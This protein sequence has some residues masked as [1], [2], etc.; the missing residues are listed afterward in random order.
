M[1]TGFERRFRSPADRPWTFLEG[2][3]IASLPTET[4]TDEIEAC[5]PCHSRRADLGGDHARYHDR[6]R[7]A[8]LDELLYFDDGQIEDE[9]YVY[10]SFLQ[11]KMHAAGVV[12]TDCHDAHSGDL[13]AEGNALCARC[14]RADVYDEPT[15]H[16]HDPGTEGSLCTDCHMPERTYMVIDDRADHR[17]G[18]PRPALSAAVGAPDACTGCHQGKSPEWA[19]RHIDKHFDKRADHSFAHAFHAA[20]NQQPE[21]EPGLVELVAAGTAPA[22]ISSETR[23]VCPR[24]TSSNC[25]LASRLRMPRCSESIAFR[26]ITDHTA[27]PRILKRRRKS[28]ALMTSFEGAIS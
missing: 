28:G 21:G 20:R 14:H 18:L 11:S 4:R 12:C 13:R 6:Y 24:L 3:A 8:A 16:F 1:E 27:R 9:V 25:Q 5:A 7:L 2:Q 22:I 10:G 26:R 23:N 17:F 19:E 15:H